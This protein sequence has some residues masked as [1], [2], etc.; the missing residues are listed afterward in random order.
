[1][2]TPNWLTDCNWRPHSNSWELCHTQAPWAFMKPEIRD[3]T[4][5]PRILS[6]FATERLSGL[7][8]PHQSRL[9]KVLI[10]ALLLFHFPVA[11]WWRFPPCKVYLPIYCL[12]FT[13]HDLPCR[14]VV[15]FLLT[16]FQL[17]FSDFWL[18]LLLIWTS[19]WN[20]QITWKISIWRYYPTLIEVIHTCLLLLYFTLLHFTNTVFFSKLEVCGSPTSSISISTIFSTAF[21]H[22]CLCVTIW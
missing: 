13:P 1:M 18:S 6:H 2:A 9:L 7:E 22:L 20:M 14:K 5:S 11:S 16:E 19:N 4:V 8:F 15:T 3:H 17:F 12:R 21:L 10:F